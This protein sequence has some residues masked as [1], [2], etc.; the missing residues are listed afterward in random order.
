MPESQQNN[1][2]PTVLVITADRGVGHGLVKAFCYRGWRVIATVAPGTFGVPW[3][4]SLKVERNGGKLM[5]MDYN[6]ED[7][8]KKVS[9]DIA[10]QD[11]YRL[12]VVVNCAGLEAPPAYSGCM[13]EGEPGV[14]E[15]IK[16]MV[17]VPIVIT[18]VFTPHL[19][20]AED[21]LVPRTLVHVMPNL[22]TGAGNYKT[23][24]GQPEVHCHGMAKRSVHAQAQNLDH[25]YR[26]RGTRVNTLLLEAAGPNEGLPFWRSCDSMVRII[27]TMTPERSG[28]FLNWEGNPASYYM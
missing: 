22:Q 18:K 9:T 3:V 6:D 28:T 27:E 24:S 4:Q 19:T 20:E 17:A 16:V 21:G 8:M 7:D 5:E 1:P 14:L 12:D 23:L 25:T 26:G 10:G 11:T 2:R 13:Y 15:R